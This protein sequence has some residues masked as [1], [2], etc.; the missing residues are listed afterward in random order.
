MTDSYVG[1]WGDVCDSVKCKG[2]L[3]RRDVNEG[4]T[5]NHDT[6]YSPL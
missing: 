5:S 4:E 1:H 6:S 2:M 3:S